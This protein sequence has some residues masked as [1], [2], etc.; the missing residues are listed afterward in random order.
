MTIKWT[1]IAKGPLGTINLGIFLG[2]QKTIP[3]A[4]VT[5]KKSDQYNPKISSNRYIK[6]PQSSIFNRV[7][8]DFLG[9]PQ[10]REWKRLRNTVYTSWK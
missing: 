6:K 3:I 1:R 8:G 9:I 7:Q 10:R 5:R 4:T 2:L